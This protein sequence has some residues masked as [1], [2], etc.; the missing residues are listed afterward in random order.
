[1]R[2]LQNGPTEV[3]R[4]RRNSP[5]YIFP[6]KE[7]K[8]KRHSQSISITETPTLSKSSNAFMGAIWRLRAKLVFPKLRRHQTKLPSLSQTDV[9]QDQYSSTREAK[10][11]RGQKCL[12]SGQPTPLKWHNTGISLVLSLAPP[13]PA[14]SQSRRG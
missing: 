6:S 9:Q 7:P 4:N 11:F 2:H 1:M 10:T 12:K 14:S 13:T 3:K 8:S 5:R